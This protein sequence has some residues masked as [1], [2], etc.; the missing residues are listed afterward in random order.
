MEAL[1][2]DQIRDA[3]GDIQ[4]TVRDLAGQADVVEKQLEASGDTDKILE[5]E[6]KKIA[7]TIYRLHREIEGF[8][9]ILRGGRRE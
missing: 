7:A 3:I 5:H 8:R 2:N 4:K 6:I 1:S 9:G